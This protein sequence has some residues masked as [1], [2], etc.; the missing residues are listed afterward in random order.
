FRYTTL[1]RS[2]G[3]DFNIE[4]LRYHR[5]IIM[6]DADVDGAHIR[7]LLLTLLYRQMPELIE[8][9]YVYIAQPPLYKVKVGREERYLKDDEEEAQFMLQVA[10]KDAVLIPKDGATPI[11]GDAL[12][13]LARQYIMADGVISRL[14]RHIDMPSLSAMA[15]GVEIN[16]ADAEQAAASAQR[17]FDAID[18]PS[19]PN[20]VTVTVDENEEGDSWRLIVHRM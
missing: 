12:G 16:L 9:G 3:P 1:F 10:L 7:T 4:K 19:I 2:I 18:D 20:S 11:S 17:L 15:E 14:S 8:G 6:T 13:E 5:I